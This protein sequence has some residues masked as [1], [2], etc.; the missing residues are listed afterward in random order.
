[1]SI[2]AMA[3][4]ESPP[5]PLPAD[6]ARILAVTAS[7]RSGSSPL[8][9]SPNSSTARFEHLDDA[10]AEAGEADALDAVVGHHL[11]GDEVAQH[12]GHRWRADQRLVERQADKIG[13]DVLD[14]HVSTSVS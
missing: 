14:F 1:M 4:V 8:T 9:N 3:K 13:F 11:H 6:A 2:A 12:A 7:A 10:P 5:G